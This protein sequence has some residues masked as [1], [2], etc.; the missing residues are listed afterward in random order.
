MIMVASE[1][2][3][4]KRGIETCKER[5]ERSQGVEER[6]AYAIYRDPFN[7]DKGRL[8]DVANQEKIR[9]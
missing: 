8:D 5:I 4:V 9:H 1:E 3:I 6:L 2:N 7:C